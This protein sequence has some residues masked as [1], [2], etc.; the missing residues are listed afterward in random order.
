MRKRTL[1]ILSFLILPVFA[2]C[3]AMPAAEAKW[4]E[5]KVIQGNFAVECPDD[6]IQDSDD[7]STILICRGAGADYSVLSGGFDSGDDATSEAAVLRDAREDM[8]ASRD[9]VF[10][11]ETVERNGRTVQ[12]SIGLEKSG[13]PPKERNS[14]YD[15]LKSKEKLLV[16]ERSFYADK[17]MIT[18]TVHYEAPSDPNA[19]QQVLDKNKEKR[20]RFLNSFHLLESQKPAN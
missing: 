8:Q 10:M 3:G 7:E 6:R 14:L 12:E 1:T 19:Y 18:L 13:T 9:K 5:V 17:R 2:G 4:D 11:N 20:E 16:F 15:M